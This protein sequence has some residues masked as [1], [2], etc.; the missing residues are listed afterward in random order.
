MTDMYRSACV[1]ICAMARPNVRV[2]DG[3]SNAC[4]DKRPFT[5]KIRICIRERQTQI[6]DAPN[7]QGKKRYHV[8]RNKEPNQ[9]RPKFKL[10][11]DEIEPEN[12]FKLQMSTGFAKRQSKMLNSK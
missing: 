7:F 11:G 5:E 6:V 12:R 8:N 9:V 2:Q 3:E 4:F 10:Y 1:S